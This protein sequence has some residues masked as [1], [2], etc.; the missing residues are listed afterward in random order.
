M[1]IF[2]SFFLILLFPHLIWAVLVC[3]YDAFYIHNISEVYAELLIFWQT[4]VGFQDTLSDGQRGR[5]VRYSVIPSG[6]LKGKGLF[7]PTRGNM[8]LSGLICTR[9]CNFMQHIKVWFTVLIS[10]IATWAI[11]QVFANCK[12]KWIHL[13][14]HLWD[15]TRIIMAGVCFIKGA[16]N[17]LENLEPGYFW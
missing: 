7:A 17:D 9:K 6:S 5:I 13:P 14:P 2:S 8:T 16:C 12:W 11:L 15:R 10:K 1:C 4:W 3:Y